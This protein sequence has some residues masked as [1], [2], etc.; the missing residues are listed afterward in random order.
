MAMFMKF[1][2]GVCFFSALACIRPKE[3]ER[4]ELIILTI[5]H[6]RVPCVGASTQ[7]CY[8]S[9]E[10]AQPAWEFLFEGIDGFRYQ[11]GK[12]YELEVEKTRRKDVKADQSEIAYKLV[13]IISSKHAPLDASFSL[14][15]KD[16][17]MLSVRKADNGEFSLLGQYPV[18]CNSTTL[19][20]ELESKLQTASNI[21]GLFRHSSDRRSLVLQ[22]L[23]N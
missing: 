14:I 22:S 4:K 8:L 19:C 17:D 21:A 15:L 18:S 23:E 1:L 2:V 3:S 7:L 9:R 13:R 6:Y 10:A 12:I 5:N 16:A 11:W 20:E